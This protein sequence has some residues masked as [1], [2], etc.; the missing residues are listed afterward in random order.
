MADL[1]ARTHAAWVA[2]A[3]HGDPGW[4]PYG[5]ARRATMHIDDAWRLRYGAPASSA[6]ES[7]V[8]PTAAVPVPAP[9][10]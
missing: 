3:T 4:E 9:R 2:F 7:A 1:A 5:T 6:G 10:D 8:G